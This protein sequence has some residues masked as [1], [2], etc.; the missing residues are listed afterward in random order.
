MPTLEHQQ[1][2][3]KKLRATTISASNMSSFYAF[4]PR[5]PTSYSK[6][7]AM[8][9]SRNG[10]G[11]VAP[12]DKATSFGQSTG[13]PTSTAGLR[14]ND[15]REPRLP[16]R[17][18]IGDVYCSSSEWAIFSFDEELERQLKREKEAAPIFHVGRGSAGDAVHPGEYRSTRKR[19]ETSST[20]SNSSAGSESDRT[21]DK[22]RRNIEREVAGR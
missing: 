7:P 22:S 14:H 10:A 20:R 16:G 15:P 5:H 4:E 12:R 6:R 2:D 13:P 11:S 19:S 3:T 1:P 21:A 18:G 17:G 9:S 8:H